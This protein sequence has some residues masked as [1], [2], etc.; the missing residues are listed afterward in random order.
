MM[1]LRL[2]AL[3]TVAATAFSAPAFAGQGWYLGLGGAYSSLDQFTAQSVPTPAVG[4]VR[5]R[6]PG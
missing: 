5:C 4:E 2:L 1:K 3:A 6:C